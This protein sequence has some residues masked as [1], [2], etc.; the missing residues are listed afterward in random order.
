MSEERPHAEC[1]NAVRVAIAEELKPIKESY[2]EMH[3]RMFVDNGKKS[4]QSSLSDLSG[5]I[6]FQWF[7]LGILLTGLIGVAFWILRVGLVG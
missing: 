3:K 6:K 2:N 7:L 4:I 1:I 5:H